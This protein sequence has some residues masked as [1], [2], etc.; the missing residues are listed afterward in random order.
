M[1][2]GLPAKTTYVDGDVFSASDINDTNGT[3]NLIGQTTNF[4]AGKNKI[5]NGDFAIWQRGT[6]TTLTNATPTY[7]P[8]RFFGYSLHTAGTSTFSQQTFTPGTAPVSGY[9]SQ[10]F[11][12]LTAGSTTTYNEISQRIE[13]VRTFA[14]QTVTISFWAKAS[15]NTTI[16]PAFA[17]N[18]GSGGSGTVTTTGSTLSVT[19]SWQRFSRTIT[20]PSITGK[21]VGTSSFLQAYVYYIPT[22]SQT[23]DIWGF[24]VESGST[25]TAFQTATGNLASE[26]A[27][28]QRYYIRSNTTYIRQYNNTGALCNQFAFLPVAMRATPTTTVITAPGYNNANTFGVSAT[29]NTTI[30]LNFTVTNNGTGFIDQTGV[31]E[32]SIEL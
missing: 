17:Q 25:A 23:F 30:S 4:Y 14:D 9:E 28:C 27:A 18:F 10:Y 24:Q 6:T 31:F 32:M 3:I 15:T 21:T 19:T 1:A 16:T 8:D 29:N 2:V 22:A 13:D 26:T 12:R 11:A 20:I 5:I 7:L